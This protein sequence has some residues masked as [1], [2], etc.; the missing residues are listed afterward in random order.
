M[1]V[2]EC[3]ELVTLIDTLAKCPKIPAT[4]QA[5]IAAVR[6][7][8]EEMLSQ[9]AKAGGIDEAPQ[10]TQ[11]ALRKTCRAQHDAVALSYAQ[12]APDCVK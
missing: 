3:D 12:F 5:K 1:R 8:L 2:P 4:A 10:A 9:L 11:D 6:G 7:K